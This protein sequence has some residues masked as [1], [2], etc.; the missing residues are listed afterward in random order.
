MGS[1]WAL[2]EYQFL[3]PARVAIFG[4]SHGGLIALLDIF[5]HPEA[6]KAAWV[7]A[8]VANMALRA[9]TKVQDSKGAFSTGG[10][11]APSSIAPQ[12][13]QHA[14]YLRPRLSKR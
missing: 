11:G 9:G 1:R 4:F 2:A 12:V 14:R 6:Y 7:I 13:R 5:D 3:D 8:P 10:Y